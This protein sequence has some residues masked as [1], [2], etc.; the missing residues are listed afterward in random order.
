MLR[1]GKFS[2]FKN[3][4]ELEVEFLNSKN[5]FIENVISGEYD[6]SLLNEKNIVFDEK[7]I[8]LPMLIVSSKPKTDGDFKNAVKLYN[9]M[10]NIDLDE[11]ND[12]R[13]WVYLS[14]KCYP[15]YLKQRHVTSRS[16]LSSIKEYCFFGTGSATS[17]VSNSISKLWWGVNQTIQK[18]EKDLKKRFLYT[19]MYFQFTDIVQAIGERKDIFKNRDLIKAILDVAYEKPVS[20]AE[21]TK[22][23]AR[24]ILNHIKSTNID[25]MN[26]DELKDLIE[27][28]YAY[29]KRF[30]TINENYSFS[31]E[32][33]MEHINL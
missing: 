8:A 25:F 9:A 32:M 22:T 7:N 5:A 6:D 33:V 31:H 29:S 18:N 20:S 1:L 16:S 19:K 27:D 4:E 2:L 10:S 11:A 17:N 3:V 24:L 21:A 26:Y 12:P 23:F 28:F 14:L 13:L 30:M 15:S